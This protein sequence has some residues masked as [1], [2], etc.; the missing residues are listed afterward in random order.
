MSDITEIVSTVGSAVSAVAACVAAVGVWYARH[1]LKTSRELAQLAFEDGLAKEYRELAGDLS[2]NALMGKILTEQEYEDA[3]DELYRYVDLTNEQVSLRARDRITPEVW[4]NW[5]AGIKSNLALPAFSRAWTEIKTRS[6][7]FDE[8]RRLE[9]ESF[10][11][12]PK[13]WR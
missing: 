7:G 13:N 9:K 2:K 8:L 3:F 10:N 1:Q 11:L 6:S 5:A 12:D 4:Q